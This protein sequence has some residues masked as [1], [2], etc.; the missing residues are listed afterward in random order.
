TVAAAVDRR[1]AS[2]AVR[3]G[4]RVSAGQPILDYDPRPAAIQSEQMAAEAALSRAQAAGAVVSLDRALADAAFARLVAQ[5]HEL[6]FAEGLA[7]AEAREGARHKAVVALLEV[8]AR[9][10]A[11]AAAEASA[12]QTLAGRAAVIRHERAPIAGVVTHVFVQAGQWVHAGSTHVPPT[13]LVTIGGPSVS[14]VDVELD[15]RDAGRVRRGWPARVTAKS[16]SAESLPA[17]VIS[18]REEAVPTARMTM[19]L[20]STLAGARDGMAVVVR[21]DVASRTGALTVPNHALVDAPGGDP[22]GSLA[23]SATGKATSRV[24]VWTVKEGLIALAPLVLG[25]RGDAYSEVLSGLS[26]GELVVTGPY[27]ML[28]SMAVGDSAI[29]V[30]APMVAR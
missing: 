4:Q 21:L 5:R 16:L 25:L 3:P 6:L 7:T 9:R 17:H 19:E 18:I 22:V 29:P 12:R 10:G 27:A 24:G 1:V 15:P 30:P 14:R 8:E 20:D 13:P 11:V 23:S 26:V 28:R 2:V